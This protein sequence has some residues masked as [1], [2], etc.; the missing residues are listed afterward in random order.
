[1]TQ[2]NRAIKYIKECKRVHEGWIRA[3]EYGELTAEDIRIGG[4]KK[5]HRKWV[6]QYELVLKELRK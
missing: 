1:M 5:W 4:G 2:R 6:K 3:Q